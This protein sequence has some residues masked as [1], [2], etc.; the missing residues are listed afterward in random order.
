MKA[1]LISIQPK[2]VERIAAGFKTL[3]IRKTVPNLPRPFKCYIYQTRLR[4]VYNLLR[5]LGK[6]GIA[7][8]LAAGF[9]KVV[10][11]FVCDG[12]L[13]NCE[14]ANA[15]FA[16]ELSCVPRKEI[17]KYSAGKQV[18]GWHI[19]DLV[20]YDTPKE[21]DWFRK[22]IVCKPVIGSDNCRGCHDC[23]IKRPPQSWC[24]VQEE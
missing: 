3:E 9:G 15:D 11:E 24:Y 8:T 7:D 14:M 16:E 6:D 10:G 12:F 22:P 2:W 4:W 23:E 17:R 13:Y 1:V 5:R 21:L 20:I 18:Y 19:S